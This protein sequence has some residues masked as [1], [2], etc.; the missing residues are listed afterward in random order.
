MLLYYAN[1]IHLVF[2]LLPPNKGI[3]KIMQSI[4]GV[5]AKESNIILNRT[6][7]FWQDE[8][9]DRWIRTDIE[10]YF[11]TRYVLLN[12]VNAALVTNW[13]DW[14]YTYCHPQYLVL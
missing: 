3:S 5:S 14:E 2:E 6:G 1:H 7:K 10:L 8:S 13:H 9:Y 12:P 4:K 11:I